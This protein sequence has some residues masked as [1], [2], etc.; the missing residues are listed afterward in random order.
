MIYLY[1]RKIR[2]VR[3]MSKLIRKICSNKI[4]RTIYDTILIIAFLFLAYIVIKFLL[5]TFLFNPLG[6]W[7]GT[8]GPG[9]K[10]IAVWLI[11]SIVAGLIYSFLF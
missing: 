9:G 10:I 7:W 2:G 11:G 6:A 1:K 4:T 3:I 5:A 8:L